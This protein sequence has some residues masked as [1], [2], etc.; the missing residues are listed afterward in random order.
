MSSTAEETVTGSHRS[1][2]GVFTD[3]PLSESPLHV[4]DAPSPSDTDKHTEP[5]PSQHVFFFLVLLAAYEFFS[6]CLF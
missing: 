4:G 6:M 5:R 2:P 3:P 1:L